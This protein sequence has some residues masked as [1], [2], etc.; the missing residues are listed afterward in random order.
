LVPVILEKNQ[1]FRRH[2]LNEAER[3][4]EENQASLLEFW[5][6]SS[7]TEMDLDRSATSV[8]VTD[9]SNHHRL[10]R[11]AHHFRSD[12]LVSRLKHATAAERANYELEPFGVTWPD[13]EADFSIR[14][15]LLAAKAASRGSR[16]SSGWTIGRK[17]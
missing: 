4:I 14:G 9:E 10:G 15:L 7:A 5:M 11:R 13:V 12:G 8:A 16:S 3:I 1:G 2:E 17:A 6:T